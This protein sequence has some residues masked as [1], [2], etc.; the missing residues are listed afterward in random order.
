MLSRKTPKQRY[1]PV[2]NNFEHIKDVDPQSN[3]TDF[4]KIS[5]LGKAYMTDQLNTIIRR[6]QGYP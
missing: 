4:K 6:I 1:L 5:L 3:I 2:F